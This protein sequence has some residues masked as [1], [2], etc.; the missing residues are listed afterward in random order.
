MIKKAY[1]E[2]ILQPALDEKGGFL[3]SL[4]VD[5]Q[6]RIIAKVD[7]IDGF[8]IADCVDLSRAIEGNLDR[9]EEDFELEVSTPGLNAEFKVWEQYK[10]NEGRKVDILQNDGE[11][12]KGILT[13]V[14]PDN[15]TVETEKKVKAE[16]KKKKEVVTETHQINFDSVKKARLVL[17]F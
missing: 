7:S 13:T 11:K 3:V 14:T 9:E 17:D 2:E 4:S 12:I 6:N 1:I 15:F 10:K 5:K 16:G 8:T